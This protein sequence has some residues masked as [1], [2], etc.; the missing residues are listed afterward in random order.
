[1]QEEVT[2]YW[3]QNFET[4]SRHIL[5]PEYARNPGV[6][7]PY[8]WG[9]LCREAIDRAI[10]E[11]GN[12][13]SPRSKPYYDLGHSADQT[14]NNWVLKWLL[15]H[16]ARYRD[17]RNNKKLRS[18][19]GSSVSSICYTPPHGKCNALNPTDLRLMYRDDASSDSGA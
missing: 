9:H 6:K 11:I 1:M 14:V 19:D 13:A 3:V 8:K 17:E 4:T 15:W 16:V 2:H 7:R 18:T 12:D 10:E 5:K